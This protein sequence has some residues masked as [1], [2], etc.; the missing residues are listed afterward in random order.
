MENTFFD[1]KYNLLKHRHRLFSSVDDFIGS[2]GRAEPVD[3]MVTNVCGLKSAGVYTRVQ[4]YLTWINSI[5]EGADHNV[6][7]I[8]GGGKRKTLN[9]KTYPP[10]TRRSVVP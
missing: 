7:K 1:K 2:Y 5:M 9:I 6:G 4:A 8:W 10:L 3:N